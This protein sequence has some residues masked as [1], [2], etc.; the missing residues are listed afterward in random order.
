M[1][2]A[3]VRK[4]VINYDKLHAN[5][6]STL[7]L[8][9][10]VVPAD[11]QFVKN[12]VEVAVKFLSQFGSGLS[13]IDPYTGK[14]ISFSTTATAIFTGTIIGITTSWKAIIYKY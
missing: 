11:E 5:G 2:D 8:N 1:S 7:L 10:L 9:R 12:Q 6:T 3:I 14:P 4:H 13:Q